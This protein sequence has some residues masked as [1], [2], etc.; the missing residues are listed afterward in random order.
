[1]EIQNVLIFTAFLL[2]LSYLM[3]QL[4]QNF[5]NKRKC[6]SCAGAACNH[7]DFDQIEKKIKAKNS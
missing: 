1:M 7:I 2:S 5:K 4:L 6:H 3:F